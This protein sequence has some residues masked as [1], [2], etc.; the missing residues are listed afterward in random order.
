MRV[1]EGVYAAWNLH[2][3]RN[4]FIGQCRQVIYCEREV[5]YADLVELDWVAICLV[6]GMTCHDEIRL[7]AVIPVYMCYSTPVS[8]MFVCLRPGA[9]SGVLNRV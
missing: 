1:L 7:L 9:A 3:F 4:E 2:S 8:L 5:A 6:S